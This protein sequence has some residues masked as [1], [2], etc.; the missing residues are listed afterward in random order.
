MKRYFVNVLVGFLIIA[1]F[2]A[3][4]F[5]SN[6]PNNEDNCLLPVLNAIEISNDTIQKKYSEVNYL[7][8]YLGKFYK[9]DFVIFN[10][11]KFKV[12]LTQ[13]FSEIG[14]PDTSVL[15]GKQK[16]FIFYAC[17]KAEFTNKY[18][19]QELNS[20]F[21]KELTMPL[22]LRENVSYSDSPLLYNIKDGNYSN[23]YNLFLSFMGV[24]LDTTSSF[25][26]PIINVK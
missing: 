22:D 10:P 24:G 18:F 4:D 13:V 9:G 3:C 23:D 8:V 1:L 25:D 26:P 14:L 21:E 5:T 12:Q 6:H 15:I 19:E 20:F 16:Y 17:K 11:V 7:C 2:N